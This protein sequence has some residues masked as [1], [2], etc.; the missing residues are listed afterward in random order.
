MKRYPCTRL[1][2]S[3]SMMMIVQII[4]AIRR[5]RMQSIIYKSRYSFSRCPVST[6]KKIFRVFHTVKLI[7]RFQASLVENAVM[8]DQR[9]IFN[10]RGHLPPHFRKIGS[11][12]R[13]LISK[14]VYLRR[15]ITIK[16]RTRTNQPINTVRYFPFPHRNKPYTAYTRPLSVS[17]FKIYRRK[18]FH[19]KIFYPIFL[20][21]FRHR[22]PHKD[23]NP[24]TY[25][26]CYISSSHSI[27]F[28]H[29]H[30]QTFI[31]ILIV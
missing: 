14:A 2:I 9:I 27:L 1:R 23:N 6:I 25:S 10:Q 29:T 18:I 16:I 21:P 15:P 22:Y 26:T 28:H 8:C 13:I 3:Q 31:S 5:D 30:F 4:T 24:L 11:F 19:F 17:R 20:P 7:Y 12:H